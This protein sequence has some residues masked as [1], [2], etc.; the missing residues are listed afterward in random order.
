MSPILDS[1]MQLGWPSDDDW[2]RQTRQL[3]RD[4]CT[5]SSTL[6]TS[7][8]RLWFTQFVL[9][10]G[11]FTMAASAPFLSWSLGWRWRWRLLGHDGRQQWNG[12]LGR[13]RISL[14]ES[15][16]NPFT[17]RGLLEKWV[18]QMGLWV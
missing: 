10:I 12:V 1:C 8:H 5:A 9:G 4:I 7:R 15:V 14:W 6:V 2:F 13:K 16:V 18:L 3:K 11:A 17:W